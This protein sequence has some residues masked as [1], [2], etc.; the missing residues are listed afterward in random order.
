MTKL[1]HERLREW[2][3]LDPWGNRIMN[4][5]NRTTLYKNFADEIERDYIPR[6]KLKVDDKPMYCPMSFNQNIIYDGIYCKSK[7][8]KCTSDCAWAVIYDDRHGIREYFC[9]VV[10]DSFYDDTYRANTRPLKG[11]A[12]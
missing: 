1:L 12:E 6:S 9:A 10:Q 11:D 3:E 8:M 2:S 5:K 7:P 4:D